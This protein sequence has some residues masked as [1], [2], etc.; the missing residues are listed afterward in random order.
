MMYEQRTIK[1]DISRPSC[2]VLPRCSLCDQV[3]QEG[4]RD[5]I[6]LKKA[7]ICSGCEKL[8]VQSEVASRQYQTLITK[9]KGILL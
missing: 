2:L 8:I 4:I 3:P 1:Q 5:G 7:F 6:R 9:L